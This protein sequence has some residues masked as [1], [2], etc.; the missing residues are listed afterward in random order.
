MRNRGRIEGWAKS[1]DNRAPRRAAGCFTAG[2]E[3]IFRRLRGAGAPITAPPRRC[4]QQ[5]RILSFTGTS[6]PL[7]TS[8]DAPVAG[9]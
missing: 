5:R 9:D 1:G 2:G 6:P 4:R 7:S 3:K 8:R